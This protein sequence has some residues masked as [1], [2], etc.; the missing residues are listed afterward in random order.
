MPAD[1]QRHPQ[2]A[3]QPPT[4]HANLKVAQATRVARDYY[5]IT[6][7]ELAMLI[8]VSERARVRY[9]VIRACGWKP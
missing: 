3:C 2:W 8:P 6:V 1:F 5:T 4:Q 7:R 9:R